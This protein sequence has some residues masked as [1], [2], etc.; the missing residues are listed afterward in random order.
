M[1]WLIAALVVVG[2]G[3]WLWKGRQR[4]PYTDPEVKEVDQKRFYVQPPSDMDPP[5]DDH[6]GDKL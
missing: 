2:I 3:I 6:E 4:N 5:P 1:Q